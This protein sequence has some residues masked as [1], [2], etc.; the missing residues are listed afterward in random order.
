M[1]HCLVKGI[2]GVELSLESTCLWRPRTRN[3]S[4]CADVVGQPLQISSRRGPPI[5]N[6]NPG[7]VKAFKKVS[8]FALDSSRKDGAVLQV[9]RIYSALAHSITKTALE[10]TNPHKP[11]Q[12]STHPPQ[13]S[14]GRH[15]PIPLHPLVE[16][17]SPPIL[18]YCTGMSRLVHCSLDFTTPIIVPMPK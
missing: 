1:S 17:S 9:S 13:T 8:R 16:L 10:S 12:Q 7:S 2:Q 11:L 3:C 4:R 6:S 15:R 14:S 18:K 5:C